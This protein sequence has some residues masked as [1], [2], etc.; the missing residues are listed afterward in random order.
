MS[1]L[2][3]ITAKD[4]A[5]VLIVRSFVAGLSD[6]LSI[7]SSF[8]KKG[9]SKDDILYYSLFDKKPDSIGVAE[10]RVKILELAEFCKVHGNIN[11]IVDEVGYVDSKGKYNGNVIFNKVFGKDI[12]LWKTNGILMGNIDDIS[13]KFICGAS[14]YESIQREMESKK[15]IDTEFVVD[16]NKVNIVRVTD[17]EKA[18]AIFK[19][20]YKNDE[21]FYDTETNSVR[22]EHIDAK[23]LT[24]QLTGGLDKYTSYVF[25][26]DHKDI[27]T[28]NNLKKVVGQGL[29]WIL[30]SGKK[31]FIH[32]A[33]FDLL[34]TKKHLVS[35]LDFYK[36]NIYDTMLIY[37]FLSNTIAENVSVGL[38]ES[39]FI[40]KVC[41]DW[42]T[43]LAVASVEIRK[44]L[45]IKKEE[46][47]Y[48]M[49]NPDMLE[50]YAGIDTIV[51]AHYWDMLKELRDNHIARPEVD[52]IETT[53]LKNWQPIIQSIQYTIWNGLP[54][55]IKTAKK[56][57]KELEDKITKLYENVQTDE[58][59][60]KAVIK[61]NQL[62]FKK[63][64]ESY[65]KKCL[66]A[67]QKGKVFKGAEPDFTKGKYDSIKFNVEFNPSSSSHKQ[68]LFFDILGIKPIKIT[69]TGGATGADEVTA[70]FE[71]N[72]EHKVL[73]YFNEIA[74]LEKEL[75]TY[76]LPFIELSET[77]FDGF[78]R[79]NPVPLNTSLR[80]RTSTP[81]ILNIPKTDFK[82]CVSMPNGDFI[83][84]LDYSAL[85]SIISL[86]YTKD[87][88]RLAMYNAGITDSHSVNAIIAG[89][90][91]EKPEY[92]NLDVSNEDDV[93]FI[94]KNFP[95]DR[96]DAKAITLI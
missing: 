71:A 45:K 44:E 30:E 93:N 41:Q 55:D 7:Q 31:I 29:K 14:R 1:K 6:I 65:K 25:W 78:I 89:K 48:E 38:K 43:D 53:W 58:A 52:L 77:S 69:K 96:Q 76:V 24:A 2:F 10:L 95:T 54:F 86:N 39:A 22:W 16:L 94:K 5:K 20:L 42:E 35:D 61:I 8:I 67:K 74:K 28:T 82:K 81:N 21:I 15:I 11:L 87:K 84:Q 9:F 62:G 90:A 75:G 4:T 79:G 57:Q 59:T 91:L 64:K 17:G 36:V 72:P 46:F 63:A 3:N 51:L 40:N 12:D 32:N 13:I 70:M 47:N 34:W 60:Q 19:E 73:S 37:H 85:E 27:P 83:F 33:N 26:I 80:L 49:F 50:R 56:Q 18:K 23:I 88:N 66:E 92:V 68:V